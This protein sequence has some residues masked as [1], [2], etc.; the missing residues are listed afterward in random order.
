MYV[1]VIYAHSVTA[2]TTTAAPK[3]FLQITNDDR[4]QI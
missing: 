1:C 3:T 4:S 2:N